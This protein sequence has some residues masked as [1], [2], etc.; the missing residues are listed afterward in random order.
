[1]Y[2]I[3]PEPFQLFLK[4]IVTAFLIFFIS[5]C[6]VSSR[7]LKKHDRSTEI[8]GEGK[9]NFKF[10]IAGA[11]SNMVEILV[12]AEN[13]EDPYLWD[14]VPNH[15]SHIQMLR[16]CNYYT[17][18]WD[19]E[20]V[21]TD[22]W[23]CWD[24]V[25][26]MLIQYSAADDFKRFVEIHPDWIW[27]IGNEPDKETQDNL[28]PQEY[29]E[30]YGWV[31][32][33]IANQQRLED[34]E[35]FPKMVLCQTMANPEYCEAAYYYLKEIIDSGYWPDW[36]ENMEVKET[37]CAISVHHYI[38]DQFA[39]EEE[40]L[41]SAI[42]EWKKALNKFVHWANTVDEGELANKP[43]WITEFGALQAFCTKELE[44]RAQFDQIDGLGCLD[45]ATRGNG[46]IED[47][48]VFYGRNNREGIWGLQQGQIEY[49]INPT[50]DPFNNQ[51]DWK[52]AW[53][54]IS[55]M[56]DW[57]MDGECDST[58]WLFGDNTI[59]TQNQDLRSRSGETYRN[60]I[61]C[62]LEGKNCPQSY[63]H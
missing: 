52:A 38:N 8:L 29:A 34:P 21:D 37:V 60:T 42:K 47:D 12:P 40:N 30:F 57:D 6:T 39:I 5:G 23:W 43:L 33:T 59:C 56:E 28:T 31:A 25:E 36:P 16:A 9:K 20:A 49:F 58:I 51:G 18:I 26:K 1:M 61:D 19:A 24:K 15:D 35:A 62:L 14:K 2:R 53:W 44:I 32:K 17:D 41:S 45:E 3:Q 46:E 55:E 11:T 7:F 50:N 13:R 4:L 48:Y 27:L 22:R 10:S 63:P 54:F